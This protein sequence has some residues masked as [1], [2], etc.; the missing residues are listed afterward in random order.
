LSQLLPGSL[1]TITLD[2]EELP[3]GKGRELYA[4]I[5]AHIKRGLT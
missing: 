1:I 3:A 4:R 5:I 2:R